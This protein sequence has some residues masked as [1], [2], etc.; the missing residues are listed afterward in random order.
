MSSCYI[1]LL[2]FCFAFLQF[3]FSGDLRHRSLSAV[4]RVAGVLYVGVLSECTVRYEAV[5]NIYRSYMHLHST[6]L[7][8]SI[9][10]I[11]SQ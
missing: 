5:K 6:P 4:G 3:R 10:C 11:M 7:L 1:S 2:S 9:L 8:G